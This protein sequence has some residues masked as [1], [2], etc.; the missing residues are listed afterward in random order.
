MIEGIFDNQI[1]LAEGRFNPI[2]L[3]SS[4]RGCLPI[5][6]WRIHFCLDQVLM[7]SRIPSDS[8]VVVVMVAGHLCSHVL[9][10]RPRLVGVA[11]VDVFDVSP[12]VDVQTQHRPSQ[13]GKHYGNQDVDEKRKEGPRHES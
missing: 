10:G 3:R 1:L 7:R 2:L 9:L 8:A 5:G 11:E 13:D 6:Q 4:W 12:E